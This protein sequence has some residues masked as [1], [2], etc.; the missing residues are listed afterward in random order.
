[1]R[2]EPAA[3]LT[4]LLSDGSRVELTVKGGS[5]HMELSE[6]DAQGNVWPAQS[7]T[8][9]PTEADTLVA[10]LQQIRDSALQDDG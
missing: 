6:P 4:I 1:M 8:L 3:G 7:I 10:A 9:N 5:V 2:I